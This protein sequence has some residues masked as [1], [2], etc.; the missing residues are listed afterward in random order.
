M[1]IVL[2]ALYVL[3]ANGINVPTACTVCAWALLGL[4]ILSSIFKVYSKQ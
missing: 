2:I 3:E 4:Q 1:A